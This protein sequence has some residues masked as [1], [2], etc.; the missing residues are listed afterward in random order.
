MSHWPP[1][2]LWLLA[3][4]AQTGFV[5]SAPGTNILIREGIRQSLVDN[6][7]AGAALVVQQNVAPAVTAGTSRNSSAWIMAV[8]SGSCLLLAAAVVSP[9]RFAT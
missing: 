7:A 3:Y 1:V 8:Q 6:D 4:C 2:L 5:A 9:L